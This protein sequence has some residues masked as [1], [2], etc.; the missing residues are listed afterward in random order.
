MNIY[1]GDIVSGTF[2]EIITFE[3]RFKG[4][5]RFKGSLIDT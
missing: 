3:L 5:R 2:T 1:F 4:K